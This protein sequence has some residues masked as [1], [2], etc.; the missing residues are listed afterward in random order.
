MLLMM[1]SFVSHLYYKW[2]KVLIN[3][4]LLCHQVG[5]NYVGLNKSSGQV[6]LL[7]WCW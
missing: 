5:I 6:V 1:N 7:Q 2:F 4:L 3:R